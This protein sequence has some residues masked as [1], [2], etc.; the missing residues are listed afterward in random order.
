MKTLGELKKKIKKCNTSAEF[1]SLVRETAVALY[2]GDLKKDAYK[3]ALTLLSYKAT[4]ENWETKG[5][6]MLD[7]TP[8]AQDQMKPLE[9]AGAVKA[10]K[11]IAVDQQEL[12]KNPAAKKPA[13][14][15]TAS[16]KVA[17]K[18]TKAKKVAKPTDAPKTEAFKSIIKPPKTD[19]KS[20]AEKNS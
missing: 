13:S 17:V 9:K 1:N 14:K 16:K 8:S 11:P 2:S 20:G 18:Q 10:V 7:Y 6:Q 19:G 12:Q 4:C 3:R 15:K 5:M